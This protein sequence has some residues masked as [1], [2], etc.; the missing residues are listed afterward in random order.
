M[1]KYTKQQ[2]KSAVNTAVDE[3][4]H[5]E[6]LMNIK[7]YKKLNYDELSKETYEIKEYV[8]N[9]PLPKARTRMRIRSMMLK[10]V[11]FNF[12][13]DPAFTGENWQFSCGKINSQRHIQESCEPYYDL[14]ELYDLDTDEGLV[15]YFDAVL[16]R[17]QEDEH[18]GEPED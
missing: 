17:R 14:R 5:K 16:Q 15:E 7:P 1:E 3:M 8:K 4:N 10:T 9:L 18:Q 2:W 12:Q 13:S 11:K 6:L